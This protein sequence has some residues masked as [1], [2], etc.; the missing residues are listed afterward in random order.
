MQKI[1][2]I[3]PMSTNTKYTFCYDYKPRENDDSLEPFAHAVYYRGYDKEKKVFLGHNSYGTYEQ[4]VEIPDEPNSN[5]SFF[6]V[7]VDA[8]IGLTDPSYFY[9]KLPKPEKLEA[10]W[11]NGLVKPYDG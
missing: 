3:E 9:F 2:K 8:I 1:R 10:R 5:T 4:I 11:F 6:K 7:N